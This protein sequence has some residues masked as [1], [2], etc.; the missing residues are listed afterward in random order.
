MG[1]GQDIVAHHSLV[2]GSFHKQE[3]CPGAT[4]DVVTDILEP[5]ALSTEGIASAFRRYDVCGVQIA[6]LDSVAAAHVIVAHAAAGTSCQVHLC[7]AYTLSLVDSDDRL[8][9]ALLAADLN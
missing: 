9:E 8:R 1:E 4:L 5:S 3:A 7:N 6:D 2:S